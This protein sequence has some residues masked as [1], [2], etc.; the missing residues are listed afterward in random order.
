MATPERELREKLQ[1]LATVAKSTSDAAKVSRETIAAQP[2][3]PATI[4]RG[5]SNGSSDR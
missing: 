3:E 4:D 5:V 1:R 2:I